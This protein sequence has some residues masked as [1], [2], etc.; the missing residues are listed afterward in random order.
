MPKG[1]PGVTEHEVGFTRGAPF[2]T[3]KQTRRRNLGQQE[4]V[5]M[6]GHNRPSAQVVVAK[7]DATLQGVYDNAG[8]V[9]P[10]QVHWAKPSCIQ[11]AIHP[12]KSLSGSESGGRIS[13]MWQAAFQMPSYEEPFGFGVDV[14]KA[15]T[16][17]GH[18]GKFSIEEVLF[19]KFCDG[20]SAVAAGRSACAT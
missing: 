6:V 16:G 13:I 10:A 1:F 19:G 14:R 11:V 20:R 2:E 9:L 7:F 4:C 8:N 3:A 5:D 17:F 18:I 15:A 12:D